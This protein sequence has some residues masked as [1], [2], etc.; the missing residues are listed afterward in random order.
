MLFENVCPK[1]H[2]DVLATFQ[3]EANPQL[4]L[5]TRVFSAFAFFFEQSIPLK[6]SSFTGDSEF[7]D[8]EGNFG[9]KQAFDPDPGWFNVYVEIEFPTTGVYSQDSLYLLS[10]WKNVDL[11]V[12]YKEFKK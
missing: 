11:S 2:V 7:R 10:T 6:E 1:E 12:F 4:P 8:H 3:L 9:L 5:T